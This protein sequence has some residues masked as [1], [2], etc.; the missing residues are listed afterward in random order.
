MNVKRLAIYGAGGCGRDVA[1]VAA[2]CAAA[3]QQIDI[4][5]FI[6]DDPSLHGGT[7][8]GLPVVSLQGATSSL[9]A[10]YVVSGIGSSRAREVTMVKAEAAGLKPLTLIHPRVTCS[11]WI[12]I[13][14]GTVIFAG[15][16]L[17][18]DVTLQRHVH[19]SLH[20]TIGHDAI[21]DD[22]ATLAPGAH[23]SG[24]V[25]IGKRVNMGTGAVIINGRSDVPIVIGDDVV[26]GASAC[27]TKSVAPG[28]TVVG[29]P[30]RPLS[31]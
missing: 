30:A 5:C 3:G 11:P 24:F 22:Y 19:I 26:I 31:K 1:W 14:E 20:C 9:G 28:L 7:I 25:Q 29:V 6:D 13:G 4:V 27:V 2:D 12:S 16:S 18:A 15:A 8:R 10:K 17:A 21:L 23:V